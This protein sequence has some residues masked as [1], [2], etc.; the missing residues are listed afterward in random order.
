M[1]GHDGEDLTEC[2]MIDERLEN[3]E[4]AEE[5]VA[6]LFGKFRQFVGNIFDA[7]VLSTDFFY[8][9][10]KVNLNFCLGWEVE[11]SEVE[12]RSGFI[13]NLNRIVQTLATIA[14]V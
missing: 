13:A 6:E 4:I 14:F 12:S 5:L 10:P 2:P 7:F 1:N 8:E 9:V 3:G 11:Q